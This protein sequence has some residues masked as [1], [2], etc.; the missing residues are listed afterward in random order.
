[1]R[2]MGSKMARTESS[3]VAA[4]KWKG[5]LD[6]EKAKGSPQINIYA[7]CQMACHGSST[8]AISV[9][10]RQAWSISAVLP[11]ACSLPVQWSPRPT[12]GA[13]KAW[14]RTDHSGTWRTMQSNKHILCS[15]EGVIRSIGMDRAI[16]CV[17]VPYED[18]S[19]GRFAALG[20][21]P[22]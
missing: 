13:N 22:I 5:T 19:V 21:A 17:C 3:L 10:R 1:M 6:E 7:N 18:I 11:I 14:H 20:S 4:D 15:E 16:V 12:R 9:P 8:G 2:L